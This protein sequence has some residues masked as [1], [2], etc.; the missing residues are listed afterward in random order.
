[1][2]TWHGCIGI[3]GAVHRKRVI[4][5]LPDPAVGWSMLAR[6]AV[7]LRRLRRS[8]PG[9]PQLERAFSLSAFAALADPAS[10]TYYDKKIA[11]GK[12]HTHALLCLA[13]RRADVL[14][15]AV[16]DTGGWW[17]GRMTSLVCIHRCAA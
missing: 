7:P 2:L 8:R 15:S 10:R 14:F 17:T 13:S 6:A 16:A 11:Q 3:A 4:T 12:H 5:T 9:N 1:M